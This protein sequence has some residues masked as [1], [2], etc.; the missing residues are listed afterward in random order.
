MYVAT[1]GRARNFR[2][3]GGSGWSVVCGSHGSLTLWVSVE[4]TMFQ[5]RSNPWNVWGC[6]YFMSYRSIITYALGGYEH[7]LW[8]NASEYRSA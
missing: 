2:S 4:S 7:E 3:A 6:V 8:L 5:L 1:C